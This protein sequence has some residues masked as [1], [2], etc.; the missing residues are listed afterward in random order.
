MGYSRREFLG[1]AAAAA[2][3]HAG[4]ESGLP[5]RT[6][7]RTGRKVSILAFGSG[8]RW[9]AYKDEDKAIEAMRRA[10]DAGVTYV[11]TAYGYGN[12]ESERRAGIA[13]QGRRDEI[14]LATKIQDRGADEAMRIF[15][16]SLKR[17]QTDHVDLLH[18]HSLGDEADLA[19]IEAPDGVLKLFYKLRDQ[20]V[21]RA[22]G[23]TCHQDPTVLRTALER[24]DF[25]CTQMAL[26][27]ARVGNPAQAAK[28]GASFESVA[29]PVAR[30]K[31][32]G[33]IAMKVF[34]QEYLNG[35]AE[36][37]QLIRYSLT[38]PG[39]TACVI[40]MPKLE[41]ID[42]NIKIARAYRPMPAEEMREL[43]GKLAVHK[44]AI[45]RF[46]RDHVDC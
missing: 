28:G 25:D 32:M 24:H 31:K 4:G 40:G 8:S 44:E 39:V 16:G 42:E 29:L 33:V 19:K 21:A 41:H 15:E 35:K 30:R 46:F 6:L 7:G 17:L 14:F 36:P 2:T 43:S 3:L 34:A 37:E 10:L 1:T 5:T 45:D 12:G 9:L 26:N 18:I 27:A 13:L 20:K 23:I 22:I 38:L 11:D